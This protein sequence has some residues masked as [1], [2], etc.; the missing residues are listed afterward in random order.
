MKSS[1]ILI[2]NPIAKKSSKNKIRQ[3]CSIFSAKGFSVKVLV[4]KQKGDAE[5]FARNS[6]RENPDMIV[7]AGGDGTINEIVNGMVGSKIP[8]AIIPLGTTNVLAKEIGI[9]ENIKSAVEIAIQNHFKK[10]S[11]GKITLAESLYM[12][13]YFVL[14]A[15]IGY[16]GE[17]VYNIN[18][19]LKKITGK[20][21]YIFSGIKTLLKWD[22]K[23]LNFS[24]NGKKYFS[25]SAI[26]GKASKYGG[27]FR[28]TPDVKLT[29]SFFQIALFKGSSRLDMLR[30]I[31]GIITGRLLKME[32]VEFIKAKDIYVEGSAHIQIDGDYFGRTPARFGIAENALNLIYP[33]A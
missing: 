30:Y 24:A 7:A 6:L 17:T 4:T 10:I 22:K 28:V 18:N 23:D 12:T 15:G 9:P 29:D 20:G 25:N 31:K 32:D 3:A 11:L 26:I 19:N 21:A 14:M 13:R 1:V 27:N 2:N 8:F 33:A 16:D 5:E